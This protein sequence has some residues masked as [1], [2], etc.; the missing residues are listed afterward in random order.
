MIGLIRTTLLVVGCFA[1]AVLVTAA[2]YFVFDRPVAARRTSGQKV[3][4][5]TCAAGSPNRSNAHGQRGCAE[6]NVRRPCRRLLFGARSSK[7]AFALTPPPPDPAAGRALLRGA[8]QEAAVADVARRFVA[9]RFRALVQ[10]DLARAVLRV[11][12]VR[13][14]QPS[15]NLNG[16]GMMTT[17]RA[18]P[19]VARQRRGFT[20]G[21]SLR[22]AARSAHAAR[23]ASTIITDE[24]AAT[25]KTS[26]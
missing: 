9:P 5:R 10:R 17:N 11:A 8:S 6:R 26:V 24:E 22:R 13:A 4:A 14:T 25:K 20:C 15:R 23:G 12:G 18:A 16:L 1:V 19:G 2:A 3:M 7:V 21:K